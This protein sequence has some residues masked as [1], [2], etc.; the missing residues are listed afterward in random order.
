MRKASLEATL[1]GIST[2]TFGRML[3]S[4]REK[5]EGADKHD[6][7]C[8]RERMHIDSGGR[9]LLQPGSVKLAIEFAAKLR[10]DK[11]PGKGQQTF[12]KNVRCGMVADPTASTVIEVQRG[13]SGWVPALASEVVGRTISVP[14][15]G[16]QGGTKRVPRRFPEIDPPWR[17]HVAL[18]VF[19]DALIEHADRLQ[20]YL[21]LAG[22]QCGLGVHRPQTSGGDHGMFTVEDFLFEEVA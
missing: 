10:S 3:Q 8:W 11:I 6:I 7:R 14:S 2:L 13:S 5:G 15:D 12:T 22:W 1:V 9:V 4:P 19:D 20:D 17:V 16:K 21:E 18:V